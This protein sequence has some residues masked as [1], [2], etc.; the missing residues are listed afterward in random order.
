MT[1]SN[2]SILLLL[3]LELPVFA[4]QMQYHLISITLIYYHVQRWIR[5]NTWDELNQMMDHAR[6]IPNKNW[7]SRTMNAPNKEYLERNYNDKMLK[8]KLI[9]NTVVWPALYGPEVVYW[10][11]FHNVNTS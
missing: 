9:K 8:I 4:G 6:K 1:W 10:F 5:V 7:H 2:K 3:L 11:K